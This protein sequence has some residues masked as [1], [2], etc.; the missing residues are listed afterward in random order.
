MKTD[1]LPYKYHLSLLADT[2]SD[3]AEK[4]M[5]KYDDEREMLFKMDLSSVFAKHSMD[6]IQFNN[7]IIVA[8]A[9]CL[10]QEDAHA[11]AK[12]WGRE[13]ITDYPNVDFETVL[14][15]AQTKFFCP[16][17]KK[18][19][20]KDVVSMLEVIWKDFTPDPEMEITETV[21][22]IEERV[23]TEFFRFI[24]KGFSLELP[25]QGPLFVVTQKKWREFS[26]F[27]CLEQR[28]VK[29]LIIIYGRTQAIEDMIQP[30]HAI[31]TSVKPRV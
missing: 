27:D 21:R 29:P 25:E 28:C 9:L 20:A 14:S 26:P 18:Q 3:L 11:L 19:T 24:K 30:Q 15:E 23:S 1:P 8:E 22:T 4:I 7:G 13:L 10:N 31:P 2:D 6:S 12:R 17:T 5:G 16:K